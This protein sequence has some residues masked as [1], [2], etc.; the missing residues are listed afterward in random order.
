MITNCMLKTFRSSVYKS[1]H[2]IFTSCLICSNVSFKLKKE[3]KKGDKQI[4]KN[5]FPILW[6]H[7]FEKKR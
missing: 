4:L 2:G 5:C 3:I 1:V 6:L 7:I